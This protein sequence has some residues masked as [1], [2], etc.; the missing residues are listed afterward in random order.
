MKKER[1]RIRIKHFFFSLIAIAFLTGC[2]NDSSPNETTEE[3]IIV[4]P[5][6]LQWINYSGEKYVFNRIIP[7][8]ELDMDQI[9]STNTL[10]SFGDGAEF[11]NEIFLYKKDGSLFLIDN[12]GPTEQWANFIKHNQK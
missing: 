10:T 1:K 5:S 9:I 3:P 7:K 11:G 2:I 6:P 8:G 12:T 4:E